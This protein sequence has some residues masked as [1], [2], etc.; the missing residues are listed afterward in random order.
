M[1]EDREG[2]SGAPSVP[3]PQVV[4]DIRAE[5]SGAP[6]KEPGWYPVRT[7]PNEQT[8]WDGT[9]W[10]G[11]R[12][13]SAGT[14]WTEVGPETPG[15]VAP[16]MEAANGPRL[17]SANP[18]APQ[19]APTAQQPVAPGVTLGLFLLLVCAV[20]MMVGSVT[21]WISASTSISGSVFSGVAFSTSGAASGVDQGISNLIGINGF[22]T[23]IAG[24]VL[25]VFSGLMMV[26]E[27]RSLRIVTSLFSV[28][29][30]GLSIFVVVR[31]VEKLRS[32]HPIHGISL[33]VGWGAILVLGAAVVATLVSLLEVSQN[34]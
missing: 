9:D 17:L 11:R 18:Y 26:T 32:A 15:T 31:L 8:Y 33:N 16:V 21:T 19:P 30:L 12:H 23:L 14:G 6:P 5:A 4:P 22:I 29:S 10:V 3:S 13:W 34:R 7:N 27:E 20:A 25:L 2:Q 24:T 28:V 1:A